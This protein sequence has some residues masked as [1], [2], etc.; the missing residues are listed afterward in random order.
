MK[1]YILGA[2][3]SL[4][5]LTAPVTTH[6]AGLTSSQIQA[7][8]SL[9]S[10]FGA[11]Q[12]VINNVQATLTGTAPT[13]ATNTWCHTF[14][15]D[16]GVG[17][18]GGPKTTGQMMDDIHSL[19]TV[20]LNER[21]AN[22]TGINYLQNGNP[23]SG[24]ITFDEAYAS[25]VSAFQEKYAS[26]ILTPNGLTHG[27]GYVGP[28]TRAKLNQ[29]YGCSGQTTPLTTTST[30]TTTSAPIIS[31]VSGI[32]T[33]ESRP[34]VS[35]QHLSGITSVSFVSVANGQTYHPEWNPDSDTSIRIVMPNAPAIP[36]GQYYLYLANSSGTSNKV[37]INVTVQSTASAPTIDSFSVNE[38]SQVL[39]GK[40]N[41]YNVID[42]IVQWSSSNTSYCKAASVEGVSRA[43]TNDFTGSKSTSGSEQ[44][45]IGN[46]YYNQR[47]ITLTCYS[48]DGI[49]SGVV[50]AWIGGKG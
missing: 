10:S 29:L 12:S 23:M 2:V 18:S 28:S 16:F 11:D 34:S 25:A 42:P 26:A 22:E 33:T 38:Y 31:G 47:E 41:V 9:L 19:R 49:S 13:S 14:N 48:Q 21:L 39:N 3:F 17:V 43:V 44:I 37:V 15:T 36:A 5:L 1:K 6:A 20:L 32:F 27:T 40:V 24:A 8:L 4:A 30:Q 7:I 50:I 35:G 46:S 45:M